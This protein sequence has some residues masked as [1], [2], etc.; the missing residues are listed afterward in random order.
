PLKAVALAV[1]AAKSAAQA[2][3]VA[4]GFS[5]MLVL[6][7]MVGSKRR[8]D[9]E[10]PKYTVQVYNGSTRFASPTQ[11]APGSCLNWKGPMTPSVTGHCFPI[12]FRLQTRGPR[13][14]GGC[15]GG[16]LHGQ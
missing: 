9:G 13:V 7:G 10:R 6:L 14:R 3:V 1:P 4:R 15:R 8:L 16:H 2:S 5:L 12:A 11:T